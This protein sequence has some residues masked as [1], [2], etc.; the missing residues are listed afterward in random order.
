MLRS[1]PMFAQ[2]EHHPTRASKPGLGFCVPSQRQALTANRG[3]EHLGTSY[4]LSIEKRIGFTIEFSM[5]MNKL[6]FLGTSTSVPYQTREGSK[7]E[8]E[9]KPLPRTIRRSPP[10]PICSRAFPQWI[11]GL[12][13]TNAIPPFGNKQETPTMLKGK[14]FVRNFNTL[15]AVLVM[16]VYKCLALAGDRHYVSLCLLPPDKHWTSLWTCFF[17]FFFFSSK[18]KQQTMAIQRQTTSCDPFGLVDKVKSPNDQS[19]SAAR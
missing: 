11:N 18:N 4:G 17:F 16:M 5:N 3:T 14:G 1:S 9:N 13:H 15:D 10:P 7:L 6:R 19:V 8:R 12:V 2:R